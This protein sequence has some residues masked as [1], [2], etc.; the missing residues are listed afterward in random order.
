MAKLIRKYI[1]AGPLHYVMLYPKI[2]RNDSERGRKAKR[3]MTTAAQQQLNNRYSTMRLELDLAANYL[4]GDLFITLTYDDDHLPFRRSQC[5]QNLSFFREKLSAEYKKRGAALTMHWAYEHK[6]GDARW[7]IHAVANAA[8]V[9]F[10]VIASLWRRGNVEIRRLKLGTHPDPEHPGHTKEYSYGAL[11]QYMTKERPDKLGQRSWSYTM[12]ARHPTM[13]YE[14][15][16]ADT[17]LNAPRGAHL[18][19][20][21]TQKNEFGKYERIKFMDADPA[22][23]ATAKRRKHK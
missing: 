6:H 4:P 23:R 3:K 12:N 19:E 9:D 18:L 14:T 16:D 17:T 7:H 21:E 20:R 10:Q 11:A 5:M 8:D 2:A 1:D 22:R 13:D 15:V